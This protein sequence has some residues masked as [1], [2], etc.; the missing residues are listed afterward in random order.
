MSNLQKIPSIAG[1]QG[2]PWNEESDLV[3][4]AENAPK[5]SIV[6]PSYNQGKFLEETIRSVILQNYP[7][8]EIIIIDGG[9]KDNTIEIIKKYEQYIVFWISEKDNGQSHALN[10]GYKHATG[11]IY[12][13]LNSDDIYAKNSFN[14]AVKAFNDNPEKLVVFGDYLNIDEH[15]NLINRE[16]AFDF[17]LNQFIYEGFHLN[18]QSMFWRESLHKEFKEFDES[19][20]RTMDYDMI[21][22]FGLIASDRKFLRLDK[23]MGCF[24]R[25]PEQKTIGLDEK[26]I[27]EHKRIAENNN[28]SL[29]YTGIGKLYRLKN[30]FRRL[31]WYIKRGGFLYATKKALGQNV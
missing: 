10:K 24:R 12:G 5:I 22:R 28:L 6:I 3:F 11:Q 15:S 4:K 25:H 9:S 17:S 30:R 7:N 16:F 27:N 18:A 21:L 31:R 19:L 13:W 20:H 2:W 29:K 23:V 8:T 1:K 26:V 14:E